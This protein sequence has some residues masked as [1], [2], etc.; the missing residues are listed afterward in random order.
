MRRVAI[1]AVLA[2][3]AGSC[4][5]GREP[6]LVGAVYPTEG[7]QGPGGLQEYRGVLLAADLANRRGGVDG[8]PIALRLEPA[9]SVDAAPQA[10]AGLVEDGIDLLVG[11]YGSTVSR[12]A[13]AEAAERGAFFLETGA[14]GEMDPRA[15]P[16]RLVFRFA[17]TGASL[18]R[19][20]V[21]FV[22][23]L[24]EPRLRAGHPLRYG[25]TFVD[26]VYGRA[27]AGG[28]LDEIR[29]EGLL[30]SGTFPYDPRTADYDALARRIGRAGTEVLV[31]VAYIQD[32]VALRRAILRRGIPL[33]ASIGTSSSYCM[34][35]FGRRLG[36]DAT[37]LFASDKSDADYVRADEL[38]DEAAE[39]LRWGR[40]EY[41]SRYRQPMSAAALSGFAAGWALFH[42]VL[43][44]A[45]GLAPEDVARAAL[46]TRL[47][48]GSLPNAGGLA[49]VP[50][51][52]PGAGSNLRAARVIW[53]WI[54]SEPRREVVWPPAL[55][56]GRLAVVPIT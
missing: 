53:E 1:A 13:A 49:L 36:P 15:A 10:V 55:A 50:P 14:V 44:D 28:A 16:G 32:G 20:A 42:H 7:G 43:P 54:G 46:A 29:S 27:V 33:E 8:R 6:I 31:V 30:L 48:E 39:V 3:V 25:V 34:P 45:T 4:S 5:S 26:D 23:S 21:S 35:Q 51:G 12:P 40:D 37:G 18:G 22:R 38:T 47:P 11:S 9:D 56:T 2:L 17:P 24:V 52:R 41:L 19:E